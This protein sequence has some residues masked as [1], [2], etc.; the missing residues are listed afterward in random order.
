MEPTT[1]IMPTN[2]NL[3]PKP[4]VAPLTSNCTAPKSA[5]TALTGVAS[6][7]P[8]P[9]VP[10]PSAS[11]SRSHAESSISPTS[12]HPI[13]FRGPT[14][15]KPPATARESTVIKSPTSSKPARG[16]AK[17]TRQLRRQYETQKE[18]PKPSSN[19]ET[20]EQVCKKLNRGATFL[21]I[22]EQ[23]LVMKYIDKDSREQRNLIGRLKRVQNRCHA[24][25]YKMAE[26]YNTQGNLKAV[27]GLLSQRLNTFDG[28]EGELMD[29][30]EVDE[31]MDCQIALDSVRE[32]LKNE[33]DAPG[34]QLQKKAKQSDELA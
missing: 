24:I 18:S 33:V 25:T 21:N 5:K 31:L 32:K 17:T 20:F 23:E 28:D 34:G 13:A 6:L 11:S 22:A 19:A 8:K 27:E 16:G 4:L 14:P 7:P 3:P 15:I 29:L 1:P 30:D 9:P 26:W 12:Q 10:F 2:P